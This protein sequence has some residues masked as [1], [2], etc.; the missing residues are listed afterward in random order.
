MSE[1]LQITSVAARPG[2]PSSES[3]GAV[4]QEALVRQGGHNFEL[5]A[6]MERRC[7]SELVPS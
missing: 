5:G 4:C 3:R 1:T 2:L 7:L 6:R